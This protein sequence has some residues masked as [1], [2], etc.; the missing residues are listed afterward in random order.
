MNVTIEN[1]QKLAGSDATDIAVEG[2]W[3]LIQRG[4]MGDKEYLLQWNNSALLARDEAGQIVGVLLYQDVDWQ[5]RVGVVLGYVRPTFRRKG[6]YGKLWAAL[7]EQ[8]QVLGRA[9][10]EGATHKENDVMQH[11][12][13][14]L[15]RSATRIVYNFEVPK[16]ETVT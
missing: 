16:K 1:I 15:N 13:Q 5:N 7:I 10:I 6:V 3:D 9:R 12:M 11:V 2:W 14:K 8:A 4:L